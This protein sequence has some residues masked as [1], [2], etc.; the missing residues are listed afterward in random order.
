MTRSHPYKILFLL[1]ACV[2]LAPQISGPLSA[3]EDC[4]AHSGEKSNKLHD[5]MEEMQDSYRS[6][7]RGL[8]RPSAEDLPELLDAV[9]QLQM[10]TVKTKTMVPSMAASLDEAD[11]PAFILAYRQKQLETLKT[12]IEM[13]NKLLLSDFEAAGEIWDAIRKHRSEGHEQFKEEE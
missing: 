9:Q 2:M 12:L 7:G 10:L 5:L 3:C 1:L 11:R 4:E 13:E 8:R 6:L